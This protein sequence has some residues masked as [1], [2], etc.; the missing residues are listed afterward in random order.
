[1]PRS[2]VFLAEPRPEVRPGPGARPYRVTIV[3]SR[4]GAGHV[5]VAKALEEALCRRYP[6]RVAVRTVDAL[7][8]YAP[9]P[10]SLLP[11]LYAHWVDRFVEVYGWG[12]RLSDGRRRTRFLLRLAWPSMRR[13]MTRLLTDSPADVLVC[14]HSL[15]NHFL[16]WARRRLGLDTPCVT[17][18]TDP[19]SAHAVWVSPDAD[20]VLVG[21]EH[22]RRKVVAMGIPAE[23]VRTTGL[24]VDPRFTDHLLPPTDAR[25]ILGW[26]PG[27]PAV[28]LVGGGDGVGGLHRHARA[29]DQATT[30]IQIALVTGRN[31]RLL[32]RLQSASW[33][34]PVHLYGFVDHA[35]E[36]SL[37]MSATDLLVTKAGPGTLHDAYIAGLPIILSGAIPSQEDGNVTQVLEGGA[38]V[39][40]PHPELVADLVR[41]WLGRDRDVLERLAA[42]S[43]ALARPGAADAA[44]A[45]VW[46]LMTAGARPALSTAAG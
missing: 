35:T 38:G 44:A 23:R 24:P 14:V 10:L 7:K 1:M 30:G 25:G 22:A 27:R 43:R 41:S 36:M 5:Q 19:V 18:I 12:H 45:E 17:L 2:P 33:R 40:A 32:R 21:S 46:R 39:W 20:R 26:D 29:I 4:A 37:L 6:D 31:R 13:A 9:F 3:T 16:G 42:G 8:D 28:L 11:E 34:N 15:E